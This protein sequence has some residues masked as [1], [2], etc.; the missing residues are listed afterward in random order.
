MWG[1]GTAQPVVD[2]GGRHATATPIRRWL[3][4]RSS[5]HGSSPWRHR[6]RQIKAMPGSRRCWLFFL[7]F[8]SKGRSSSL[9]HMPKIWSLDQSERK[10]QTLL[11][12]LPTH[13]HGSMFLYYVIFG[14]GGNLLHRH[15]HVLKDSLVFFLLK[16][17][18]NIYMQTPL[19]RLCSCFGTLF[20]ICSH[21]VASEA[22]WSVICPP[23][24]V[25]RSAAEQR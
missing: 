23:P 7:F 16:V 12:W 24:A 4:H 9:V 25:H 17:P 6:E 13:W 20:A 3:G 8:L 2:L 21:Q 18:H 14:Y 5:P 10:N 19:K 22:G 1:G 11:N 15:V